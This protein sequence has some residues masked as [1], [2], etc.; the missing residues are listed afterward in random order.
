VGAVVNKKVRRKEQRSYVK[1]T[2]PVLK[3]NGKKEVKESKKYEPLLV[4]CKL[5][6]IKIPLS[7]SLKKQKATIKTRLFF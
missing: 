3:S 6:N 2:Y 7:L 4:I 5:K 1:L